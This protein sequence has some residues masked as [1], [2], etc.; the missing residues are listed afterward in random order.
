MPQTSREIVQRTLTFKNPERIPRHIWTLPWVDAHY[1]D[2]MKKLRQDFPMDIAD[3]PGVFRPSSKKKGEMYS[4][5]EFVD[6][7][8]CRFENIQAGVHGQVK[9]PILPDLADWK[10]IKPPYE[11]LPDN[12]AKARDIVNKACA[13][14]SRF[15]HGGCCPRPFERYQ[16]IRG[17]QN[18][19]VDMMD[20][21]PET[22]GLLKVIHEFHLKELE[23]WAT[24][25]IDALT[26]M[27]DWGCQK[28]LLIPPR[29]WKEIFRPMYKDYCDIAHAHKKF[30]FMHSDGYITEI[31][32]DL[33]QI[34]VD[35]VNSQL[36]CMDMDELAKIAKGKI[37]FW[38]EI[39]R[40]HI[41]N[42]PNPEDG[43]KGVRKVAKYLYMPEGG[44]IAQ[45]EVGSG[46]NP[47]V[48]RAI[49]EEWDKVHA[50]A[51]ARRKKG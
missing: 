18:A 27:D 21:G 51:T 20:M 1:P 15:F 3:P 16:F 36:F 34:G 45:C 46:G 38:G 6:D 31:Y 24:T 2:E 32:P 12:P 13:S 33:I 40:Q 50:E 5:G 23:F 44:I 10:S 9:A 26:F 14:D 11:M 47:A 22:R 19:L 4:V 35:A 48:A 7:W 30:M 29:I 17:S 25:D 42:S 49:F 41:M 37:T 8:G 39:D 43:R 28:Q